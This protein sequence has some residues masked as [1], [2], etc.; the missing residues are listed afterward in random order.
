MGRIAALPTRGEVFVDERGGGR[1]LR[2]SWH[3]EAGVVVLSLWQDGSCMG[4]FRL[5]AGEVPSFVASLTQGLTDGYA[6]REG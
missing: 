1:C 3:H 5:P 4:T 6:A 2:A